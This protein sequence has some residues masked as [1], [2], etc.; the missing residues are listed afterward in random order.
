MG[1]LLRRPVADGAST[2][3]T[4]AHSRA[5][6]R[7]QLGADGASATRHHDRASVVEPHA[8][9]GPPRRRG[10]EA[11]VSWRG[12]AETWADVDDSRPTAGR[13]GKTNQDPRSTD[14]AGRGEPGAEVAGVV[15]AMWLAL[16]PLQ[17]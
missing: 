3:G 16:V 1:G 14:P 15:V 4:S 7:R 9:V 5:G 6:S 12:C 2:Y 10:R 17:L 8:P 13:C 11:P